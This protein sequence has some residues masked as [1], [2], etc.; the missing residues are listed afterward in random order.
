MKSIIALAFAIL[1]AI[2]S[3][4]DVTVSP[5]TMMFGSIKAGSY[6]FDQQTA[7]VRNTGD[8]PVSVKVKRFCP[9]DFSVSHNCYGSLPRYF[10]CQVTVQFS[11]KSVGYHSCSYSVRSSKGTT[12]I[13]ISGRGH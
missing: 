12:Y 13:N 9:Q 11:P 10:Q 6:G 4:A 7:Y 3:I 5:T 8:S 1:F 2:P